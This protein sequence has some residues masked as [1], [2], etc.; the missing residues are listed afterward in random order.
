MFVGHRFVDLRGVF[1]KLI[2]N[3]SLLE[4]IDFV[5]YDFRLEFIVDLSLL[6]EIYLGTDGFPLVCF[7]EDLFNVFFIFQVSLQDSLITLFDINII[8]IFLFLLG[9]LQVN[10]VFGVSPFLLGDDFLNLG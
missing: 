3:E 4:A 2:F 7:F 9:V 1:P 5:L 6:L 8:V 10:K